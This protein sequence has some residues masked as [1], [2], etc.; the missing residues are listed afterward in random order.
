M[1]SA[2]AGGL[3][4]FVLPGA[5]FCLLSLLFLYSLWRGPSV[6]LPSTMI[7]R[8]A[9]DFSLP[10]LSGG[11][12]GGLSLPGLST[13]DLKGQVTLVNIFASWCA[14][15]RDE[16]PLLLKLA[17]DTRVRLTGID[18][19]DEPDNARR[20][21]GALGNPYSAIGMDV[22][23]RAAIDWG[24]YGVPESFVVDRDGYIVYK[25]VGPLTEDAIRGPINAAIEK[26][27]KGN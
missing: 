9:P 17:A 6:T 14:P 10:A 4:L 20:F 26:A 23:G 13:G 24:V 1:S 2:K 7:G 18:Y 19:K 5:I 3:S 12:A 15:C 22:I 27:A 25:H 8:A 16:H 21:L 11:T